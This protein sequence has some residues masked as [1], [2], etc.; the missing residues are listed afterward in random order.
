VELAAAIDKP[1][2]NI[3]GMF[4][5]WTITGNWSWQ[6]LVFS[7]GGNMLNAGESRVAFNEEPGQN[8]I[9]VLR[10]FVDAGRMGGEFVSRVFQQLFP[11]WR[12]A[13]ENEATARGLL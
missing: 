6:G 9:A 2:D 5:D 3:R 11:L 10:K 7:H 1:A 8:A 4:F 13:G 12:S